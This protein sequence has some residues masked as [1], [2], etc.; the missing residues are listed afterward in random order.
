MNIK[1]Y[2]YSP[3][4]EAAVFAPH[5]FTTDYSSTKTKIAVWLQ[6]KGTLKWPRKH[7]KEHDIECSDGFRYAEC[8]RLYDAYGWWAG[9]EYVKKCRITCDADAGRFVCIARSVPDAEILDLIQEKT[10]FL[11]RK[12]TDRL[13]CLGVFLFP[14]IELDTHLK[15]EF[16]YSEDEHG[17]MKDFVSAKWGED[18]CTRLQNLWSTDEVADKLS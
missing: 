14:I 16:G 17:S 12:N 7:V 6:G 18:F 2:E 9:L 11:I 13:L 8:R 15:T 4:G 3:K 1:L 10:G 5:N